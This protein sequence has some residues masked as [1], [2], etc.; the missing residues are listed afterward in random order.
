MHVAHLS[1]HDFRSYETLEID[2]DPGVS[3]FV[4]RNGQGK[5]NIVEAIDWFCIGDGTQP[6]DMLT[7][8]HADPETMD[9]AMA[10]ATQV[11]IPGDVVVIEF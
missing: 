5:T 10:L 7:A 4:G 11:D 3:S 1:L 9:D 8:A 2:L 6:Y